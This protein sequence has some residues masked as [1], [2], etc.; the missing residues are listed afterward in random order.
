MFRTFINNQHLTRI[1]ATRQSPALRLGASQVFIK[2]D[3]TSENLQ[4]TGEK[5][6]FTGETKL[7]TGENMNLPAKP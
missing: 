5:N 1:R 7:F 4:N 3:F 6:E 2:I